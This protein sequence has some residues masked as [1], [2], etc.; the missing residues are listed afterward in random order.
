MEKNKGVLDVCHILNKGKAAEID[1]FLEKAVCGY[2]AV[3][4]HGKVGG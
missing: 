2:L 1:V 3:E 4:E